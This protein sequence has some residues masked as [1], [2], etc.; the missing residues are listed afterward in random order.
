MLEV[1]H[2]RKKKACVQG[3]RV[4]YP[5]SLYFVIRPKEVNSMPQCSYYQDY[6]R[7]LW[8]PACLLPVSTQWSALES[9]NA[10]YFPLTSIQGYISVMLLCS[11]KNKTHDYWSAKQLCWR[12]GWFYRHHYRDWGLPLWSPHNEDMLNFSDSPPPQW[13]ASTTMALNN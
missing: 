12:A 11:S 3:A 10:L 5:P 4:S 8:L 9:N 13:R 2:T 1:C 6:I 7:Q